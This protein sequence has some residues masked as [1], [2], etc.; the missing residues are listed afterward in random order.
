MLVWGKR[1]LRTPE[2]EVPHPRLAERRFALQP[3]ADLVGEDFVLGGVPLGALLARVAGQA[4]EQIAAS[5]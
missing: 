5:W 3:L 1:V 2:L 4:C